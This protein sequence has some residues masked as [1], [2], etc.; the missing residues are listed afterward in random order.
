MC[1]GPLAAA[2]E[3]VTD[4]RKEGQKARKYITRIALSRDASALGLL[5][6]LAPCQ[7]HWQCA[8]SV[9]VFQMRLPTVLQH[10]ASCQN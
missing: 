10:L 5:P 6:F 4:G 1:V 7:L 8:N 3:A 9:R 2:G